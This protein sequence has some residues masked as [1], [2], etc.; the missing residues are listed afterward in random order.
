MEDELARD[1][2]PVGGPHSE[3]TSS[4]LSRNPTPGPDQVP[5]L[6]P[7]PAPAPALAPAPA[8]APTDELFKKFIKA[9]M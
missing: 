5:A 8:S 4:A 1:P 9:Y 2:G 3:N 7:A 6:I